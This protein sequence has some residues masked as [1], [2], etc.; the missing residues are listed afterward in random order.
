MFGHRHTTVAP[1]RT[2]SMNPFKRHSTPVVKTSHN[3]FRRH[4]TVTTTR[5]GS[6]LGGHHTTSHHHTTTHH[7]THT[8]HPFLRM[9]L[10]LQSMFYPRHTTTHHTRGHHSHSR[11]MFE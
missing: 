3:P 10:R 1:T 2:R 8:S 5:R 4:S 7:N 9:K 11:P 6:I